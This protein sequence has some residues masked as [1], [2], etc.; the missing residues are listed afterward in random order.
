MLPMMAA[1]WARCREIDGYGAG[2]RDHDDAGSSAASRHPD[3]GNR[4]DVGSAP[5]QRPSHRRRGGSVLGP[6]SESQALTYRARRDDYRGDP[7]HPTST[8][9]V[10]EVYAP[11]DLAPD[12]VRMMRVLS[13]SRRPNGRRGSAPLS[14]RGHGYGERDVS[15]LCS[16]GGPAKGPAVRRPTRA[17]SGSG[18][19]GAIMRIGRS[20]R[21]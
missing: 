9:M 5:D 6:V 16:P 8:R 12:W 14:S 1:P 17:T 18:L 4:G 15:G 21:K 13:P 3:L 19:A 2:R 11:V 7:C 20:L 10:R